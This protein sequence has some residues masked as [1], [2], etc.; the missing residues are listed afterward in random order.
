[1]RRTLLRG[2]TFASCFLKH[3]TL[4]R[5]EQQIAAKAGQIASSI[6]AL[7]RRTC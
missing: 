3:W 6:C 1:M 2:K 4:A 5:L 7:R